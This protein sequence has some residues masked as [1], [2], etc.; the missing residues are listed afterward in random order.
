MDPLIT[1][2]LV[3]GGLNLAGGILT[4]RSNAK[5]AQAQMKF[6]EYMSNTAHQREVKDLRAAG[7]NPI[8]SSGGSGASTPGGAMA[9]MV[10]L[11]EAVNTGIQAS[12]TMQDIRKSKQDINQSKTTEAVNR[13][14]ELNLQEQA[15]LIRA[16]VISQGAAAEASSA[17]A[18]KTRAETLGVGADN[19]LKLYAIPKAKIDRDIDI[20]PAGRKYREYDKMAGGS[21]LGRTLKTVEGTLGL[22]I[23]ASVSSAK[24]AASALLSPDI[25]SR[26]GN[27][28]GTW[29]DIAKTRLR[30]WRN[31]RPAK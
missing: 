25:W 20:S 11:G 16:Q 27:L 6:Q 18:A 15:A 21:G 5:Q 7:L 1:G 14:T 3:G 4:N 2:A 12:R 26:A 17:Q 28:A 9:R 30:L 24:G 19:M 13:Q 31:R 22:D 10:N 23:P 8:L 29:A